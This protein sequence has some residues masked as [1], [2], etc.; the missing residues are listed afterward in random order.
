MAPMHICCDINLSSYLVKSKTADLSQKMVPDIY[1][2]DDYQ[3][4]E[5]VF[6]RIMRS[7]SNQ[8]KSPNEDKNNVSI[9]Q[10]PLPA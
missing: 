4:S 9:R 1:F 5:M 3:L 10:R 7:G 6:T 8:R 2:P